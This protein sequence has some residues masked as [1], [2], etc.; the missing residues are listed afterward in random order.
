MEHER[1]LMRKNKQEKEIYEDDLAEL[2]TKEKKK[3]GKKPEPPS[4]LTC[5]MDDMTLA[6]LADAI[7]ENHHGVL[8]KKD[9]LS[10]WFA[11]FDQYHSGKGADVSRWLSLHTGVLFGLDRRTDKRQYRI[12]DP[13]VC[14]AG[15]IQPKVFRRILTPDYFERGLPARFLLAHPPFLQDRWS[16]KTVSDDICEAALELFE[17]L[18]LL[19]PEPHDCDKRPKLLPL[20]RDAKA[21]F[22]DFYNECKLTGYAARLALVGQ[23]ARSPQVG[24]VTGDVMQAACEL[25]RWF[26]NEA[27]RIYAEL[28]ETQ[29]QREQRE[30]REFIERRGGAVYEREVM[31]SFTRLKNDKLETERELTALVKAGQGEWEPVDHDGG[32]GRPARKFRL[33]RSSTS[34]QSR[35]SRGKTEKSVDVDR[36]STQKITPPRERETEAETLIGDELGVGRL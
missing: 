13:R 2:E 7:Q 9:E 30:L 22:V 31:Q 15:G 10:H 8:V 3:R 1:G 33:L 26:G 20:D 17:E 24:V 21:V 32:P 5:L 35:I 25:A 4:L 18:W 34:T 11:A 36:S 27:V 23:L 14:I 28:A 6:A 16:D 19:P 29:E 12:Y